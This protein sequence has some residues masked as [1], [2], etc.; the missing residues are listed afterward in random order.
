[1]ILHT[2]IRILRESSADLMD[3]VPGHTLAEQITELLY[4]IPGVREIEEIQA[5]RFGPY[6]VVNIT[7]GIEGSLSLAAGDEI[8]LEVE[9]ALY[10]HVEFLRRAYVHYHP[11]GSP[12]VNHVGVIAPESV[13]H[14]G[15]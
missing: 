5:H 7:I 8:A 14:A 6:L 13:I 15:Q 2:G 4:G 1:V 9:S 11:V 12:Q 3:T 10:R